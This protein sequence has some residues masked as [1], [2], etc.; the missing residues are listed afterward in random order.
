MT[1]VSWGGR[2]FIQSLGVE[3]APFATSTAPAA[4]LTILCD[5]AVT[6]DGVKVV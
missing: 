5:N 3:P 2:N 4:R 1:A 6:R